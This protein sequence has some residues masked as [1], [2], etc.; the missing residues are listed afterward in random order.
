MT[1]TLKVTP[2][3]L[4][5]TSTEF[6]NHGSKIRNI[7]SEMNSIVTGLSGIW[8]GEASTAYKNKFKELNDDIERMQKM[9]NEHV[10]DLNQMAQNYKAAESANVTTGQG[11]AGN[12][13]V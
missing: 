9:I 3:K 13:I 1:G 4:I 6:K 12:V 5:S 2:E 8:E 7:T 11:L 10:N